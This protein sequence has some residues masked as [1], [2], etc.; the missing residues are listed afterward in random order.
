METCDA[1]VS[2]H[3]CSAVPRHVFL[4]VGAVKEM[5]IMNVTFFLFQLKVMYSK[6]SVL[7]KYFNRSSVQ[8]FRY[9]EPGPAC[10]QV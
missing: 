10:V 1:A 7:A 4:F 8:A 9:R 2:D 6:N 5:I 3:F